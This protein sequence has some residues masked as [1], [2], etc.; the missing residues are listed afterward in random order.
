MTYAVGQWLQQR[1]KGVWHGYKLLDTAQHTNRFG[2]QTQLLTWLGCCAVCG[3]QFHATSGRR[4]K[5]L[6]RT[7]PEHRRM[8]RARDAA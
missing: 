2:Y 1:A 6:P 7:C 8:F 5:W 4:P 3:R